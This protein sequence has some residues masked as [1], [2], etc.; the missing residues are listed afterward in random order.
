MEQNVIRTPGC[1]GDP[2]TAEQ[3]LHNIDIPTSTLYGVL[4]MMTV[5]GNLV[6]LEEIVYLLSKT[7]FSYKRTT[8][9]W[10]TGAPPVIAATSCIGLWIPRST[11]FTDFTASIYFTI[12]IHKFLVMMVEEYGGEEAFIHRLHGVPMKISTGPCCCC[13]LCLPNIPMSRK[14]LTV[15]KSG[16]LQAALLRPILLFFATVLWTNGNYEQGKMKVNGAFLWITILS[17]AAFIL[18]LWPIGI[19]FNQAKSNLSS[20]NIVPK[21]ALNQSVLILTQAQGGIINLLVSMGTIVCAAPFSARARGAFM[22]QQLLVMEMFI[23]IL[24]SRCYYRRQYH[25]NTEEG[26]PL[27]CQEQDKLKSHANGGV[28]LLS[29]PVMVSQQKV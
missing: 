20:H 29:K 25:L 21:F 22:H 7:P 28:V 11:M 17:V 13:C 10:I 23:L 19:L 15:L 18:S 9:I 6:Y 1:E 26:C 27:Q 2:P 3:I 4:T 24:V 16:T 8:Y 5:L 14:T 12:C